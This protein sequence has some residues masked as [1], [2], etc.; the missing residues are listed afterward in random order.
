MRVAVF[1]GHGRLGRALQRFSSHEI[2]PLGSADCDIRDE[3]AIRSALNQVAAEVAVN[4]AAVTDA[5]RAESNPEEARSVNVN[6]AFAF[7]RACRSCGVFSAQIS[8]DAVLDPINVYARSKVETEASGAD[9]QV[10]T[11]FYDETHWLVSALRAGCPVALLTSNVFNPISVQGLVAALDLVLARAARGVVE[12][13]TVEPVS[14][15]GLGCAMAHALGK[16]VRL[17]EGVS[18]L[19]AEVPFPA[20]TFLAEAFSWSGKRAPDLET[21]MRAFFRATQV[22]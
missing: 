5:A 12:V 2:V 17:I 14:Y 21:D 11:N 20:R 16:D 15:H 18:S 9:V 8:S 3:A 4:S 10:R 13:G 7:A 22:G 1:G 6:G 19:A